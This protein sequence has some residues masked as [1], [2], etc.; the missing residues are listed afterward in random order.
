[1]AINSTT[2]PTLFPSIFNN[3]N[4]QHKF[5]T[6][7]PLLRS[8]NTIITY[9]TLKT[10]Y[11]TN[12][13]ACNSL[14]NNKQ[15]HGY[16][17]F[18]HKPPFVAP[19][20][21]ANENKLMSHQQRIVSDSLVMA[22]SL[23]SSSAITLEKPKPE[24]DTKTGKSSFEE[25]LQF[26]DTS[27]GG[28]GNNKVGGGDNGG[29][30]FGDDDDYFGDFDDDDDDGDEGGWFRR[31][32]TFKELYDRVFIESVLNEWQKTLKDLP[33]G[34][35]L[36]CE[37]G[38]VSSAQL[39]TYLMNEARP[40][41]TRAISRSVSSAMSRAFIGRITADPAFLHKLLFEQF[42]TIA[43]S[44]RSELKRRGER[45]RQEWDL[46]LINVLTVAACNLVVVWSLAPCCSFANTSKFG[47]Q[48]TLHKL[49]NNV[50]EA[51]YR[52]RRF[53]IH[54]RIQSFFCKAV[55]FSLLGFVA[56]AV[57]T[58]LSNLC[59]RKKEGRLSVKIPPANTN[60]L[61]YGAFLGLYTNWR[62]QMICG[63][64][65]VL[66]NRFDVIGVSLFF[67]AAFRIL[68]VQLGEISRVAWL[69]ADNFEPLPQKDPSDGVKRKKRII[70]KK[71]LNSVAC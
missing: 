18:S 4:Q 22:G 29:G 59:A 58:A 13:F 39:V 30:G 64:D 60:A 12:N 49:P 32:I 9:V 68:N 52:H 6:T 36:A 56:G 54:Q 27:G 1:M 40:T 67:T 44:V 46:A 61:G 50:F 7:Q 16:N 15:H 17:W 10:P 35:R 8:N 21:V 65:R 3:T 11:K 5:L 41:I 20:V 38:A 53:D 33:E 71:A 25:S 37:L 14:N 48:K 24:F 2:I 23:G 55:Q 47:F 43:C 66:T 19:V 63:M 51:S 62:Y 69:D 42:I 34:M 70:R 57:Q 26:D 28:N 45:M 31:R